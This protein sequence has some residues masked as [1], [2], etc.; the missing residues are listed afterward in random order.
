MRDG[1][2]KCGDCL[3]QKAEKTHYYR[4]AKLYQRRRNVTTYRCV[5][6]SHSSATIDARITSAIQSPVP[7][8]QSPLHKTHSPIPQMQSSAPQKRSPFP[9]MQSSFP[10]NPFAATQKPFN[11]P[12]KPFLRGQDSRRPQPVWIAASLFVTVASRR[13]RQQMI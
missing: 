7:L 4:I 5:T 13:L 2:L 8:K 10:Q 9:Q 11:L 3:F 1:F 6:H 12:Q